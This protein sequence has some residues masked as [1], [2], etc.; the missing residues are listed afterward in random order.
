MRWQLQPQPDRTDS[1]HLPVCRERRAAL[2][3][4]THLIS[5][6][7]VRNFYPAKMNYIFTDGVPRV[8]GF[9]ARECGVD[10]TRQRLVLLFSD[11][12]LLM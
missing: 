2:A 5:W 9:S 6:L 8:F 7:S 10:L 11:P 4:F 3:V 12:D 1:Q